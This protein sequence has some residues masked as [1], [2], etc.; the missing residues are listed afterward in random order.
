MNAVARFAIEYQQYNGMSAGRQA[1]QQAV[2][3]ALSAHAGKAPEDCDADDVR[4]FLTT[5]ITKGRHPNTVRKK[6]LMIR[7]FFRWAFNVGLV[8]ADTWMRVRG[9]P[10]PQ[11]STRMG[12]P[13]PYSMKELRQFREDLDRAW[14]RVEPKWW[15]LWRNGTSRYKRIASE[16]MR[17]QI[18]AIVALALLQGLRRREIFHLS[19][20]DMHPDNAYIVVRQRALTPNGKD[21]M[22][23]VPYT[24][25]ARDKVRRWLEIRAE[26][27]P[28][29]DRPWIVAVANVADG[30]WLQPMSFKRMEELLY[31]TVGNWQL[32]RFRHTS[33]TYWLRAGMELEV[34]SPLLGHSRIT[35]TLGYAELAR[36]DLQRSV[37]K[38][39]DRFE[40]LLGEAA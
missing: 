32:H 5:E 36:G 20:D 4:H 8:D 29:H 17:E 18:E 10:N 3:R 11:G 34:L 33:A 23:E 13:R 1:E 15:T 39:E 6:N 25:A 9:I 24:N 2:L 22:R 40:R 14:P 16:V 28:P 35:Q 19:L 38:N 27:D 37:E 12:K 31:K 26:L 30:M 7:P 21:K